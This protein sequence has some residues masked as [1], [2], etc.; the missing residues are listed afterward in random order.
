MPQRFRFGTFLRRRRR[1]LITCLFAAGC[2][3]L[4]AAPLSAKPHEVR[5]TLKD[6]K[7]PLADLAT[8][9]CRE[10]GIESVRVP[11]GNLDLGGLKGSNFVAA[12]NESLGDACRA[13]FAAV[14]R[15]D[16]GRWARER[17]RR[18][19]TVRNSPRDR[20]AAIPPAGLV[21]RCLTRPVRGRR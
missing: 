4:P 12:V 5:M 16:L 19:R 20:G 14:L 15:R 6:G 3:V 8:S 2:L 7:V 17:R 9:L 21:D 10:L 1:L 11:A 13:V 18:A